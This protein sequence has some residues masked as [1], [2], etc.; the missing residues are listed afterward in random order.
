[1][2]REENGNNNLAYDTTQETIENVP[3]QF[4]C[5][6]RNRTQTHLHIEEPGQQVQVESF[7]YLA[8]VLQVLSEIKIWQ[9]KH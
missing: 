3:F 5:E 4:C 1:M 9:K 8:I 7:L 2:T 6:V